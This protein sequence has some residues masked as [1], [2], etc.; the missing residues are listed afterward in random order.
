MT[1]DIS[2]TKELIV[3]DTP[4]S[5]LAMIDKG[6][7]AGI[8]PEGM[9]KLY[10]L[11]TDM[12]D[13]LAASRFVEAMNAFQDECPSVPKNKEANIKTKDGFHFNYMYAELDVIERII[14]PVLRKHQLTYSWDSKA[15]EGIIHCT[16]TLRHVG[17]HQVTAGFPAPV[18]T[19]SNPSISDFQKYGATASYCRRQSLIHV[20]GLRV[21]DPDPD[22]APGETITE[23]Q[24]MDLQSMIEETKMD[25]ARFFKLL[26]INNLQEILVSSYPIAL[27]LLD[28]KRRAQN[29]S[30]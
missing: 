22:A 10:A 28:A 13:H 16:C 8:S 29:D 23:S 7:A 14:Q 21:G 1:P 19:R 20:L 26:N 9:E 17:G 15:I 3:A 30:N 11:Y 27:N 2:E 12:R 6:I 25:K 5:A 4:S 24:V 18:D